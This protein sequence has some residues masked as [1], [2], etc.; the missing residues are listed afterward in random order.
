MVGYNTMEPNPIW[1]RVSNNMPQQFHEVFFIIFNEILKKKDEIT[2]EQKQKT[3]IYIEIL[4]SLC[5]L[6][7]YNQGKS[8]I[9]VQVEKQVHS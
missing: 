7:G 8:V 3:S 2:G 6:G 9:F 4:A 5:W 1:N